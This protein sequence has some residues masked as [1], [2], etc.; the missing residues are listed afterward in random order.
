MGICACD[1]RPTEVHTLLVF[2]DLEQYREKLQN[3]YKINSFH[4][5]T[6]KRQLE[7][8]KEFIKKQESNKISFE[9]YIN[10]MKTFEEF[11]KKLIIKTFENSKKF[12]I[13]PEDFERF[14]LNVLM[15]VLS[16]TK[17]NLEK[18]KEIGKLILDECQE[19]DK[20]VNLEKLKKIV[21]KVIKVSINIII[22]CAV[23]KAVFEGGRIFDYIDTNEERARDK[24]N[25]NYDLVFKNITKLL[26]KEYFY[27]KVVE[28]WENFLIS[29]YMFAG[30]SNNVNINNYNH[31]RREEMVKHFAALFNGKQIIDSL[32]NL[33][34]D[35]EDA[36]EI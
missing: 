26:R 7:I 36:S 29:P 10:S 34:I 15:F 11:D 2:E 19:E 3:Q 20:T 17:N 22:N 12:G 30:Y 24:R 28:K 9:D 4:N 6:A 1:N 35:T 25:K 5:Y 13:L 31:E 18:K 8:E 33:D 14:F 23:L 16:N 27:R 32:L 21:K